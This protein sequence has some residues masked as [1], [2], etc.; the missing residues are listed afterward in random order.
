MRAHFPMRAILLQEAFLPDEG[1][2]HGPLEAC[3][4]L[5]AVGGANGIAFWFPGYRTCP[6][7]SSSVVASRHSLS[8]G[9]IRG[10]Q[11]ASHA[12]VWLARRRGGGPSSPPSSPHWGRSW[13]RS[14]VGEYSCRRSVR[15][16]QD[17]TALHRRVSGWSTHPVI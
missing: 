8:D 1:F 6:P 10:G 11:C 2:L 16:T 12:L 13:A 4:L 14:G 7:S 3:R 5:E 9:H 17:G 15:C